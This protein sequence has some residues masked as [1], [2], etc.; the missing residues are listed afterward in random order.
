MGKGSTQSKSATTELV[1]VTQTDSG[2]KLTRKQLINRLNAVN[3]HDATIPI[4][5]KHSR[6]GNHLVLTARPEPCAGETLHCTWAEPD[7]VPS[8]LDDYSCS[9][10]LI[11]DGKSSYAVK[12]N[13]LAADRKGITVS[14]PSISRQTAMRSVK[15]YESA[16]VQIQVLQNGCMFYG[17][18]INFSSRSMCVDICLT[19]GQSAHWI[20]PEQ[21]VEL[22]LFYNE[23]IVF[24]GRCRITR[25]QPGGSHRLIL[26]I[27]PIMHQANRYPSSEFRSSRQQLVPAPTISFMHPLTGRLT[28]LL[29]KNI[30]GTGLAVEE[31]TSD[32]LLLN[33]LIIP[34]LQL[35]FTS[36]FSITCRAQ[37]VYLNTDPDDSP[38]KNHYGLAFLD[39]PADDHLQLLSLVHR[40]NNEQAQISFSID[41]DRLMEFF[42][43]VGFFYP[44]KY[45]SIVQ[46]KELL[47]RTYMKLYNECPTIARHY[48]YQD[49]NAIY[50]HMAAIRFYQNAWM[51]HHHAANND[52][53]SRA[54]LD[55]M[56]QMSR[57]INDSRNIP[58]VHLDYFFCYFRH[59]NRFPVRVYGGICKGIDDR[60]IC[61]MDSF[62]YYH[63]Q[64]D[65]DADWDLTEPWSLQRSTNEDL[66][67]L[68]FYYEACSGGLLIESQDL[69]P[70]SDGDLELNQEYATH[71]F[72]RE[73]HMFSL[74]SGGHLK[75][76]FI[77]NKADFGLNLSELTSAIQVFVPDHEEL[78][79]ELLNL[80]L[81]LLCLKFKRQRVPVLLFPREAADAYAIEVEK[82]YLLWIYN[83][84][85]MDALYPELK[86][87]TRTIDH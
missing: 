46:D 6:F 31:P 62:A 21:A 53:S 76:V 10:F 85:H 1:G 49:Y 37:V 59:N 84:I 30:S 86:K 16:Q 11:N 81:S 47:K 60:S 36:H 3:F 54:G 77:V 38:A 80:I 26:V 23:E 75:A 27:A 29:T 12:T 20:N 9:N 87:I 51:L 67:E 79:H 61:S 64:P 40:A 73:R 83:A 43:S 24:S 57:W 8:R 69:L 82:T 25:K 66:Q 56:N 35:Q 19:D 70:E 72:S 14:L 42:F 71:G 15:R 48:V 4:T 41:T 32:S 45:A 78:P 44:E 2:F 50:A 58:S 68:G 33:G 34:Q 52:Y 13:L 18:M 7:K 74:K 65:K 5:L 17:S 39:M 28:N 22:I 55:V 63:H